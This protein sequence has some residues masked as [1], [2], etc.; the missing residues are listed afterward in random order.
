[1]LLQANE[2]LDQ[3]LDPSDRAAVWRHF[4]RQGQFTGAGFL[5]RCSNDSS[6]DSLLSMQ[7]MVTAL[8]EQDDQEKRARREERLE[9]GGEEEAHRDANKPIPV[10]ARGAGELKRSILDR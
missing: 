1:V 2:G 6:W 3:T 7:K 9:G 8:D 4:V 5:F 10:G